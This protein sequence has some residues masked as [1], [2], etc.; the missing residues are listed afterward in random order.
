MLCSAIDDE[1]DDWEISSDQEV[2]LFLEEKGIT[3]EALQ[4]KRIWGRILYEELISATERRGE[5]HG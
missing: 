1:D 5:I 4:K 2:V 3:K